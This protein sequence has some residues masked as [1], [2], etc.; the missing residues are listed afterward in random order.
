MAVT[1]AKITWPTTV[2][3]RTV[4]RLFQLIRD[5]LTTNGWTL[6]TDDS[7]LATPSITVTYNRNTGYTGDNPIVQLISG[8]SGSNYT[9]TARPYESWNAGT[10]TGTN[11]SY[12]FGSITYS[13]TYD[14]EIWLSCAPEFILLSAIYQDGAGSG[15]GMVAGVSCIER[16]AGDT[17]SGTF[18]GSVNTYLHGDSTNGPRLFVPKLWNGNTG[19]NAAYTAYN[20]LGLSTVDTNFLAGG[21][22]Y[23]DEAGKNVI[24]T[25]GAHAYS[26]GRLKGQIYGLGMTTGAG[27][28]YAEMPLLTYLPNATS[29]EWLV[30]R[31]SASPVSLLSY[32]M[33]MQVASTITSLA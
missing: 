16:L 21:L 31:S 6:L 19:L 14:S 12:V 4:T 29:P 9:I 2:A 11:A 8:T 33:L 18:F 30:T 27:T 5:F 28:L 10:K 20:N 13:L 15:H 32:P 7:A 22:S 24:F 25:L 17:D 23:P 26:Y 3:N 1:T